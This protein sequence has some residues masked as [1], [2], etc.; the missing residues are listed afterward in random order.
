MQPARVRA[1][2]YV[3]RSV[4]GGRE[5]LVFDHRD[6]PEAGTQ[7]PA[8]GVDAG[9]LLTEA[10]LR[11]ITEETGATGIT[12]GS[13]L[14]VQQRPHPQTGQPQVTV[15]F[16]AQTTETRDT[17]THTVA[18]QDGGQDNGMVFRCYFIPAEQAVA[19]LADNQGEFIHLVKRPGTPATT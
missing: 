13:A 4:P 10:V 3:T 14:A 6:S 2:A 17:W 19:L 15:F 11:E 18:S 5:L 7:V 8:G 12:M 1:A 16:H 9:E